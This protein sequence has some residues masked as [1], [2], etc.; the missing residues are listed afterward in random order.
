MAE[1][2][3]REAPRTGSTPR[4]DPEAHLVENTSTGQPTAGDL[5]AAGY[6]VPDHIADDEFPSAYAT[7]TVRTDAEPHLVQD[8]TP[9]DL[10]LHDKT[11]AELAAESTAEGGPSEVLVMSRTPAEQAR[12]DSKGSDAEKAGP[13]P[14]A[15]VLTVTPAEAAGTPSPEA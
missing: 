11:P 1:Q 8:Y 15:E 14:V 3:V 2:K 4:T 5:R 9:A 10:I 12:I 13:R 6:V 7:D